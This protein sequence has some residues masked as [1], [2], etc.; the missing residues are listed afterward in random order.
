M[1]ASPADL[2]LWTRCRRQWVHH[3][4]D[5]TR[6]W[7]ALPREMTGEANLRETARVITIGVDPLIDGGDGAQNPSQI[8]LND[9]DG[10]PVAAA[11]HVVLDDARARGWHD[12]TVAALETHRRVVHG[13]LVAKGQAVLL[14]AIEWH[15]R[16]EGWRVTLFRPGTGLRGVYGVEAA[17]VA[18]VFRELALPLAELAVSYL[19]KGFRRDG[20]EDGPALFRDSNLLRRAEKRV[21]TLDGE[22]AA[23]GAALAGAPVADGYRCS[24]GCR[25]CVPRDAVAEDERFSVFTLHKGAQLARQLAGEGITDLRDVDAAARRISGK[26]RIQI[27]AV[28]SGNTYVDPA[29]LEAFLSGLVYPLFYLDFEAYA[30]SVPPYGGLAPYEHLPVLESVHRQMEPAGEV[31]HTTFVATPGVDERV[32]FFEWLQGAVGASG[33]IVV[34]SKGFESAMVRQMAARAGDIGAGDR[35]VTRMVDL[36]APFSDFAVYHPDQRGKVSL[37]RV[38]PAFTEAH[39]D[40]SPLQDGMHA[41][42]AYTRHADEAIAERRDVDGRAAAAAEAVSHAIDRAGRTP[43]ATQVSV[44][45]IVTYCGVDTMAM[46]HLVTRLRELLGTARA[47]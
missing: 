6:R 31:L 1:I 3:C 38:L 43:A 37:K 16:L 21:R 42:L 35:L 41:N 46:V 13:L 20:E 11:I 10:P 26:Q 14:D 28:L 30:E 8:V 18:W 22:I 5:G 19:E 17:A 24:Q 40:D 44:D 32:R 25:L 7:P 12:A 9:A 36:L 2:L 27:E 45:D 29:K 34:F 47:V 39:Y 4:L 15:P 23:L 33:S